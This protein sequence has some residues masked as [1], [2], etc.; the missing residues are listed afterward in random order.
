MRDKGLE[1]QLKLKKQKMQRKKHEKLRMRNVKRK[2]QGKSTSDNNKPYKL[3]NDKNEKS[4]KNHV[5]FSEPKNNQ[6]IKK[7]SEREEK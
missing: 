3:H 2:E 6:E 1:D 7:R 4:K 5:R